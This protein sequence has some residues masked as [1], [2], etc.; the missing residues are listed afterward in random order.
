MHKKLSIAFFLTAWTAVLAYLC[1]KDGMIKGEGRGKSKA[2]ADR[3]ADIAISQNITSS[4]SATFFDT[5]SQKTLDGVPDDYN[6]YLETAEGHSELLNRAGV[7][8]LRHSVENGEHISERYICHSDAAKPYLRKLEHLKDSLKISV[9]KINGETCKNTVEIYKQI[10]IWEGIVENLEQTNKALQK[11]Y[12]DFYEKIKKECERIGKG[13]YIE[14]NS[15]YFEDKIGSVLAENGCAIAEEIG[16][17]NLNL[18]LNAEEC[19]VRTDNVMK[20]IYCSACVK[21]NLLNN[22]TGKSMYKDDFIGP[23]VGWID[24]NNACK[25]AF[26]KAIPELW[27]KIKGEV[28]K[29]GCK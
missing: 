5:L 3:A 10:R 11:E 8:Q 19:D 22:K 17:A 1:P 9:Q 14:S 26:E 21:I 27:K 23:K 20:T 29:E 28:K 13:I 4:L 24:K 25:K 2:E 7:K 12:N 6:S 15:N 18:V 16:D